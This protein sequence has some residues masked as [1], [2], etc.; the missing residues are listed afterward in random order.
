MFTDLWRSAP[1]GA[2]ALVW[3]AGAVQAE[4]TGVMSLD[5]AL[6]QAGVADIPVETTANPRLIGPKADVRAAEALVDQARQGPWPELTF[7]AENFAGTGAFNGLRAT[8]YTL[9]YAQT[10]ELGGK[11]DARVGYASAN[12]RTAGLL[13]EYARA[14]LALAVR[15][16]YVDAVAAQAMVRLAG[17]ILDRKAE[18]ARI[19]RVLVEAG[20]E[21]PLRAMR[22]EAELAD[23]KV[24][25]EVAQARSAT[26]REALGALM[27]G[28]WA[29]TVPADF[30]EIRPPYDLATDYNGLPLAIAVAES[31]LASAAITRE[32]SFRYPDVTVSAGLRHAS[33]SNS[34]AFV[35]G[36]SIPFP[37]G[38]RNAGNIAAAQANS[39]AAHARLRVAEADY[40]QAVT[41]TRTDYFASQRRIEVLEANALPQA[42]EALRLVLI[43]YRYGRFPLIEVL[44]AGEARDSLL[45]ER[46]QAYQERSKAAARL[47]FL[48][49]PAGE[50]R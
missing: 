28:P 50:V 19:A 21:P 49:T 16:R 47:I 26:A 25:L 2:L 6:L 10:F 12:V 41:E 4:P 15:E 13:E 43:G 24:D 37:F 5:D 7:D 31:E 34:Q 35:L 3:T 40:R 46:I 30:P 44:A 18:L 14:E 45:Q 33:E 23:A 32:T 27:P 11:R 38:N 20:R 29:G 8:E 1:L 17:E 42:E 22:A 36:V 9:G 48:G 39:D